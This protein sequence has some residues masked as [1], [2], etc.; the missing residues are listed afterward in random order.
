MPEKCSSSSNATLSF[1]GTNNPERLRQLKSVPRPNDIYC[2][3]QAANWATSDRQVLSLVIDAL[4]MA[5]EL[6]ANISPQPYPP[7]DQVVP[8]ATLTIRAI[9]KQ[10]QLVASVTQERDYDDSVCVESFSPDSRERLIWNLDLTNPI[11]ATERDFRMNQVIRN[12][13][14]LGYA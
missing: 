12:G 11:G 13:E 14:K 10:H 7:Q 6:C 3:R 1:Q 8:Y 2:A 5:I 4:Q 9:L